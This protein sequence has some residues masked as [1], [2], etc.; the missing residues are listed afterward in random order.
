MAIFF[1]SDTHFGHGGALGLYRR[2]F[3]SVAE[4]NEALIE[5]WTE[6]VGEND[7]VWHLGDFAIRQPRS[8]TAELLA[9]LRGHKQLVTGNND[10]AATI[11]LEGWDSVQPYAE[12]VAEGAWLVLCHYPFRTWRGMGK[13]SVNLHGHCHGRLKPLPRQF[14]VGVD[15]WGFRPVT[16]AAILKSRQRAK[17]GL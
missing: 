17:R 10:T 12:I 14:D 7:V 6:A 8:V 13:G 15:V 9:R 3:A 16:L 11:E 2:P 1:I 5:R 4:M